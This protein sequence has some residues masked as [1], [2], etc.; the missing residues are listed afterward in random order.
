MT[1]N[2]VLKL[3]SMKITG[4]VPLRFIAKRYMC[5]ENNVI[6][7]TTTQKHPM[8]GHDSGRTSRNSWYIVKYLNRARSTDHIYTKIRIPCL[9]QITETNSLNKNFLSIWTACHILTE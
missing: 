7:I 8:A 5:M 9:C 4:N 6:I 3:Y 2:T 1:A